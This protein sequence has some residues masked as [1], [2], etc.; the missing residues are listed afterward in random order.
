[1]TV[2]AIAFLVNCTRKIMRD[3]KIIRVSEV[4]RKENVVEWER[5]FL[6][7]RLKDPKFSIIRFDGKES[8][9][10]FSVSASKL[11]RFFELNGKRQEAPL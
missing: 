9:I 7:S 2:L 1:M 8:S 4:S 6:Q 3:H 10:L 5:T 11:N